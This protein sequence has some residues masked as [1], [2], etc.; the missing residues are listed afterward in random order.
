[1]TLLPEEFQVVLQATSGLTLLRGVLRESAGEAVLRLLATL[2]TPSPDAMALAASYSHAFQELAALANEE[3]RPRLVDAWQAFL[4][5]RLI[6]DRNP[7]SEQV[8]R[9]GLARV[10]PALRE[11]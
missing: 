11:Q 10:S 5:A 1:M 3:A 9:V 6:D 7:W 4:A 2:A 8:E